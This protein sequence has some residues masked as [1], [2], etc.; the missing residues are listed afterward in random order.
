MRK[1]NFKFNENINVKELK[2]QAREAISI[3]APNKNVYRHIPF[4]NDGLLPTERRLLYAM[5]KDVKAFPWQ[6]YKKLGLSMGA[7]MVYVPHGE[8]N[9]YNVAV[10]LAQPWRNACVFIDGSGSYG[11]EMGDGAAAWRY[12]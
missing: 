5:Y 9:I 8:V 2:D 6:N 10:K 12:L 11:N 1:E 4:M 7:A 3:F